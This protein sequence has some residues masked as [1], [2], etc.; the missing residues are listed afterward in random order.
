MLQRQ[1]TI[2]Y[3][4]QRHGPLRGPLTLILAVWAIAY[5]AL[6]ALL[7]P[8][9]PLGLV[10]GIGAAILLF[11]PWVGGLVILAVLRWLS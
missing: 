6:L 4:P 8:F 1:S 5:P 10:I 11:V 3:V 2:I 9:G 7:A